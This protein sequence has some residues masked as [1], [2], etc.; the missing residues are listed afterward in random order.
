MRQSKIHLR[1]ISHFGEM[2]EAIKL[3][4]QKEFD[5]TGARRTLSLKQRLKIAQRITSIC[6]SVQTW[7]TE[8]CAVAE[9]AEAQ[10]WLEIDRLSLFSGY[11]NVEIEKDAPEVPFLKLYGEK[12]RDFYVRNGYF[13]GLSQRHALPIFTNIK[14]KTQAKILAE[15]LTRHK[16]T[17]SHL[18]AVGEDCAEP[19]P[20][21]VFFAPTFEEMLEESTLPAHAMTAR[22]MYVLCGVHGGSQTHEFSSKES[23]EYFRAGRHPLTL[24]E[25]LTLYI[26]HPNFLA[27]NKHVILFG[28]KSGGRYV[29]LSYDEHAAELWL[30]FISPEEADRALMPSN[31]HPTQYHGNPPLPTYGKPSAG[32]VLTGGR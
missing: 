17:R 31:I 5:M 30:S 14:W 8:E 2:V 15:A 4:C 22:S 19:P 28:Q 20:V 12:V 13:V 25:A 11:L 7:A 18:K 3:L 23:L 6:N 16:A 1:V 24:N 10:Y 26:T 21:E 27:E 29:S 9:A 32:V